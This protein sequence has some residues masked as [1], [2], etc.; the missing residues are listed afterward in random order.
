MKRV[1]LVAIGVTLV[2]FSASA[3]DPGYT[4]I[5]NMECATPPP[6]IDARVFVNEGTFCGSTVSSSGLGQFF[7]F[8]GQLVG[9][10]NPGLAYS[11]LN[12]LS[13]TNNGLMTGSPGF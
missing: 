6:Q 1:L 7:S 8:G 10:V 11:T 9:L 12:T 4:N 13:F 3:T 5:C 2:R